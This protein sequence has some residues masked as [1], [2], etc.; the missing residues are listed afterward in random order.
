VDKKFQDKLTTDIQLLIE[1]LRYLQTCLEDL[2]SRVNDLEEQWESG[3]MPL[4]TSF[5]DW[6]D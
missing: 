6:D 1:R 4:K 5:D 2:D 3:E